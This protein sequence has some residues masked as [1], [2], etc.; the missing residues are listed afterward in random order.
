VNVREE[1][2]LDA[3]DIALARRNQA[4]IQLLKHYGAIPRFS[5]GSGEVNAQQDSKDG[6]PEEESSDDKSPTNESSTPGT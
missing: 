4:S 3:L 2:D 6:N 1:D 5:S